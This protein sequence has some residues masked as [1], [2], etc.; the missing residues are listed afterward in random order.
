MTRLREHFRLPL[1]ALLL[2]EVEEPQ[3]FLF[4][5]RRLVVDLAEVALRAFHP[6]APSSPRPELVTSARH[7]RK[8]VDKGHGSADRLPVSV[9]QVTT[10]LCRPSHTVRRRRRGTRPYSPQ[11]ALGYATPTIRRR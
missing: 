2:R 10:R 1:A 9:P 4:L 8:T 5:G 6:Q 3:Q 11:C 7:M